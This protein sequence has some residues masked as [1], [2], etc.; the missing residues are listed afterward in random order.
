MILSST[1]L[2]LWTSSAS[3]ILLCWVTDGP[4]VLTFKTLYDLPFLYLEQSGQS[5]HWGI[6]HNTQ[7][8]WDS[9]MKD[10]K[11]PKDKYWF[12]SGTESFCRFRIVRDCS[13]ENVMNAQGRMELAGHQT[14]SFENTNTYRT[15]IIRLGLQ[16]RGGGGYV[17]QKKGGRKS[18]DTVPL[19]WRPLSPDQLG[20]VVCMW[21]PPVV[22][23]CGRGVAADPSRW[24]HGVLTGSHLIYT[25]QDA[26]LYLHRTGRHLVSTRTASSV[27]FLQASCLIYKSTPC[28]YTWRLT[29]R[30]APRVVSTTFY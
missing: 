17:K 29:H 9:S 15:W 28:T 7:G 22:P 21:S 20:K 13:H 12:S 14:S 24:P 2:F 18:R 11:L 19:S 25:G 1:L 4:S 23:K 6:I 8:L 5:K 16:A 10:R 3:T 30:T 26:I 27:C